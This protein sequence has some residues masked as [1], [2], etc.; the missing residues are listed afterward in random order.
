M[1]SRLNSI[2]RITQERRIIKV[3]SKY[4]LPKSQVLELTSQFADRTPEEGV[5]YYYY[6]GPL[7][8]KTRQ[9]CRLM[10]KIDKVFSEEEINKIS[11]E[12]G[13]SVIEYMGSYGCRHQWIRFRGKRI[14]TPKPTIR[15]I[16]KLINEGIEA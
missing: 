6:N 13:Y 11:D 16:R 14:Y 2:K 9:F 5:N 8:E 7:D 3:I 4:G 15:E 10:L 1:N 12:L